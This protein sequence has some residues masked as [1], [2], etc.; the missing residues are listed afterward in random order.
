MLGLAWA[1]VSPASAHDADEAPRR[2]KR[3]QH[4]LGLCWA[5]LTHREQQARKKQRQKHWVFW[6]PRLGADLLS[7]S[8]KESS[9]GGTR[10]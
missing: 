4:Y 3:F 5:M 8:Q 10:P 6:V 1:H 2:G 7:A 9:P